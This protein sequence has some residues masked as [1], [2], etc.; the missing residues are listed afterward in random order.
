MV[1][2]L[3]RCGERAATTAGGKGIIWNNIQSSRRT[4]SRSSTG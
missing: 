4:S 1:A 2:L 3:Q